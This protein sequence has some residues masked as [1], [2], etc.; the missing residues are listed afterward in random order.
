[1]STYPF[2][3]GFQNIHGLHG[4]RGCKA[5]DLEKDLTND[6][7]IWC[8]IWGCD[9][10]LSFDE[11][12]LET[13]RPQKHLGVTKG[14]KSGGFII[15]TKKGIDK[16]FTIVK[17]SNNFVWIK[18]SK[19]VVENVKENLFLVAAYI[20]DITSTYYKEEIFE[21][22]DKD[23]H[24]FSQDGTPILITGDFN[25]RTGVLTDNYKDKVFCPGLQPTTKFSEAPIRK[26]SDKS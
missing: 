12:N 10:E 3:I 5:I 18:I 14:R 26:N 22:L 23:V 24:N 25:R 6:I 21:E 19:N 11:Y 17:K 8:E 16:M 2:S 20:S 15:L 1:M 13:I 9:C 7:E 4:A